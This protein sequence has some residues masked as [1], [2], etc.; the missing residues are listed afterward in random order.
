MAFLKNFT[1]DFL[2]Y[3]L[4]SLLSKIVGLLLFPIFA[5]IFSVEDYGLLDIFTVFLT[6]IS[7]ALDLGLT[8]ALGRYYDSIIIGDNKLLFSTLFYFILLSN[9][10]FILIVLVFSSDI[11]YLIVQNSNYKRYLVIS[12][13]TACFT[14]ISNLPQIYLRRTRQIVKYG[15]INISSTILFA[16][17]SL[18][19][20]LYFKMGVIGVFFARMCGEF[21][22]L[23]LSLF[24][25]K[26]QF[27]LGF[28]F[29]IFKLSFRFSF[30]M[31]PGS[32]I[33]WL[34]RQI[35]NIMLM[36]FIGLSGVG[37]YGAGKRISM[38][39]LIITG[40]F[41]SSWGPISMELMKDQK[42]NEIY[43]STF[44]Y[45]FGFL[46]IFVFLLI[47]FSKELITLI[48]GS[49]FKEAYKVV[50]W[51]LGAGILEGAGNL[52]NL[53]AIISE[54][55]KI[56]SVA[57]IIGS[58]VNVCIAFLLINNFGIVG[59]GLGAFISQIVSQIILLRWSEKLLKIGFEMKL[60]V[61]LIITHIIFSGCILFVYQYIEQDY[62]LVLRLFICITSI[63]F[64]VYIIYDSNI[65]LFYNKIMKKLNI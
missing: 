63:A 42:R 30:P 57:A 51:L 14:V 32:Y 8:N 4:L 52:L 11:L 40:I 20:V 45:Y 34:N 3:G 55:T 38:I 9:I 47:P 12:V 16:I 27:L 6:L 61:I 31:L 43:R 39:V 18:V 29:G 65:K 49:K 17:F 60:L 25:S 53:G 37:L 28:S 50:P 56:N 46:F 15:I 33:F 22:K 19:F 7:L 24:F 26:S 62:S 54:K 13:V 5:R 1:K 41:R 59:A 23:L 2:S 35:D 48:A 64:M 10:V 44:K 58:I 36:S 21:I